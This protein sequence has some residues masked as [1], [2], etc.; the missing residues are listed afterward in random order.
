MIIRVDGYVGHV[1]I[2]ENTLYVVKESL[3]R[4]LKTIK[5]RKD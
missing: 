5:Q 3:Q 4:T 1:A 2:K